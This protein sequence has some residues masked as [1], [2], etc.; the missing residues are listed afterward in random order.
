MNNT[1]EIKIVCND[2]RKSSVLCI[3]SRSDYEEFLG[4]HFPEK[5]ERM[6]IAMLFQ[7]IS[8]E[9]PPFDGNHWDLYRNCSGDPKLDNFA[10]RRMFSVKHPE[11]TYQHTDGKSM[12]YRAQEIEGDMLLCS[13]DGIRVRFID[14]F[15][16]ELELY[17]PDS[18][19]IPIVVKPYHGLRALGEISENCYGTTLFIEEHTYDYDEED[20]A[21]D[22]MLNPSTL[23]IGN[24]MDLIFKPEQLVYRFEFLT[25]HEY[26]IDEED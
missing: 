23:N 3:G 26:V 12:I 21:L 14:V 2:D 11:F 7:H 1:Y 5:N 20:T 6:S 24:V 13:V 17:D 10:L 19:W 22:E 15:I 25:A 16:D 4:N 18:G 9:I 8:D